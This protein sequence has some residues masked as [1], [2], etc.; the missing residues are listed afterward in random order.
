[1]PASAMDPPVDGSFTHI[2]HNCLSVS[3]YFLFLLTLNPF[4]HPTGDQEVAGSTLAGPAT[5]FHGD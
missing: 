2:Q 5:F 4:T 3:T 1:M